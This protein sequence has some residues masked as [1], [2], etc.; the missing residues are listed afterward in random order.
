MQPWRVAF[1][2]TLA[3][4]GLAALFLPG[5]YE[6]LKPYAGLLWANHGGALAFHAGT[7]VLAI[8]VGIYWLARAA[9]L[10][11]LGSTLGHVDRGLRG[12]GAYDERLAQSLGREER[13]QWD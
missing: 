9:G 13:G 5:R 1:G 2:L 11:E 8:F 6:F 7:A 12:A 3:V 10:G 4:V